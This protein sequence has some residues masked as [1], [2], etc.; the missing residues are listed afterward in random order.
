MS[1]EIEPPEWP[2]RDDI[3]RLREWGT[4]RVHVLERSPSGEIIGSARASALRLD[5]PSISPRHALVAYEH[6]RWRIWRLD[7]R[8][9]L[10]QDGAAREEF[11]LDPGVELGV[12]ATTLVAESPRSIALR[13][14]CSRLLGWD[15][16]LA[17]IDLALR[18]IRFARMRR[19]PLVLRGDGDM[20]PVAHS[21]HR[22]TLGDDRP[23]VV[24]SSHRQNVPASVRSPANHDSGI[25]AFAAAAGGTLYMHS[26][27][28]PSDLSTLLE[29]LRSPDP[30]VQVIVCLDKD[31]RHA[32]LVGPSPIRVPSLRTR[33]ADVPRIVDEYASEAI[34]TLHAHPQCFTRSDRRWVIEQ[35]SGSLAEIEKATLRLVALR[36]SAT[37]G[38]AA[39][40]LGM[41][42]VSLVRWLGRRSRDA[43]ELVGAGRTRP[44]ST[45]Q[46]DATP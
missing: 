9:E 36:M 32:L 34:A 17:V 28:L 25:A 27:R 23:F 44:A 43:H 40:R 13:D 35:A 19:M 6:P 24:C 29:R 46:D 14:F 39:A 1:S 18:S 33:A 3:I 30:P 22:R 41:A 42:Y 12:G 4:D 31:S 20:V 8:G 2:A 7:S 11:T 16:D 21:L 5:D 26:K 15:R 45:S 10:Q 38:D 37:L